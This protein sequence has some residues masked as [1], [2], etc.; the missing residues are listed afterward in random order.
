MTDIF[1]IIFAFSAGILTFLNPCSYAILPIY[2]TKYIKKNNVQNSLFTFN[3][4]LR[5]TLF[6]SIGYISVFLIISTIILTVGMK[7]LVY[8]PWLGS[9]LGIFLIIFGLSIIFN[10]LNLFHKLGDSLYDKKSYSK[11]HF[12][13]GVFYSLASLS[14][15]ISLF[16]TIIFQALIS[17]TQTISIITIF[18]FYLLGIFLMI[19]LLVL[20]VN[21]LGNILYE[22]I[23][24]FTPYYNKISGL[25]ILLTGIYITYSQSL[26][27]L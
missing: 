2:F 5:L 22:Y 27:L 3:H 25:L 10:K 12:M 15:S 18:T 7:I 4:C 9:I 21:T 1:L 23:T 24:K 19:I 14:C 26:F 13:F 11:Q 16:I 6:L 17:A 8:F 20:L